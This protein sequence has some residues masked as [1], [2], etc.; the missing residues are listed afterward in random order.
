MAGTSLT[1][2]PSSIPFSV[3]VPESRALCGKDMVID[4]GSTDMVIDI[5]SIP[6]TEGL[7][8]QSG[9][10]CYNGEFLTSRS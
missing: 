4:I 10:G 2:V 3:K 1:S 7:N 5:G 9:T 6:A 8:L